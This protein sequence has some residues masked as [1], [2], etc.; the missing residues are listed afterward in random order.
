M[1]NN[2]GENK[3]Q[4]TFSILDNILQACHCLIISSLCS[5]ELDDLCHCMQ[6]CQIH[7]LLMP[8]YAGLS[9]IL[10]SYAI[11]CRVVRYTVFLCHCIQGCQIHCLHMPL[12]AGLSDTQ[13][14]YAK[15]CRVVRYSVFLCHCTQ[16]C[17]MHCLH[18]SLYAGLSNT[19]CCYAIVCLIKKI[20]YLSLMDTEEIF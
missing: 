12:Y 6:G 15:V 3:P 17:R 5:Y 14:S 10:S 2:S 1:L 4:N 8:L 7:C 16:G 13:S 9:D 18:M 19:L 11:V 20:S